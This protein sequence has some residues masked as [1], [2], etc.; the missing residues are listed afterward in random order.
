MTIALSDLNIEITERCTMLA[1]DYVIDKDRLAEAM[2]EAGD[3]EEELPKHRGPGK[4]HE[5]SDW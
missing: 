3:I 2:V 5:T 4:L 1:M